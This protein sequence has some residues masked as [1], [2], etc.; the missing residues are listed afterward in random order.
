MNHESVSSLVGS[1]F[2]D[3]PYTLTLPLSLS[4]IDYHIIILMN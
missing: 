1:T 4:V 3:S 2:Y